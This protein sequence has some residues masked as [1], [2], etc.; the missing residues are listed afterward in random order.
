MKKRNFFA[1]LVFIILIATVTMSCTSP[2]ALRAE[3][4]KQGN[5]IPKSS[6]E[7]T[8]EFKV[9]NYDEVFINTGN[10]FNDLEEFQVFKKGKIPG[11]AFNNYAN[12]GYTE[13]LE[14]ILYYRD[15]NTG[16]YKYAS[17]AIVDANV[18]MI[19][20]VYYLQIIP[21][22]FK[23]VLTHMEQPIGVKYFSV[24]N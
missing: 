16:M 23:V 11:V 21:G 8:P 14:L 19:S 12:A 13:G 20:Y 2:S 18:G 9:I 3:A 6:V 1:S 7:V 5:V 15:D 10:C 4:I 17:S 22:T 24:V